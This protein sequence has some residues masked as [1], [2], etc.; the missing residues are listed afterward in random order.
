MGL[1]LENLLDYSQGY[2]HQGRQKSELDY[3][4]IRW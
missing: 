3:M 2:I 1:T 4:I